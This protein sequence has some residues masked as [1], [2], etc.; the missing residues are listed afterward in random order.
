MPDYWVDSSATGGGDTGDSWVNAYLTLQQALTACSGG[1]TIW[2]ASD[3][4]EALIAILVWPSMTN[5]PKVISTSSSTDVYTK[6]PAT[7]IIAGTY[8]FKDNDKSAIYIGCYLKD[9]GDMVLTQGVLIIK[10]GILNVGDDIDFDISGSGLHLIDTEVIFTNGTSSMCLLDKGH[11]SF[12]WHG[13]TLTKAGTTTWD[14]EFIDN[15]GS[16]NLIDFRDVDLTG[17]DNA[18]GYLVNDRLSDETTHVTKIDF[19][20]CKYNSSIAG[21]M[22]SGI[23]L[24]TEAFFDSVDTTDGYYLTEKHMYHGIVSTQTAIVREGKYDGT[25]KYAWSFAGL[26]TTLKAAIPLRRKICDIPRQD[27]SSDTD[28]TIHLT[29]DSVGSGVSGRLQDDEFWIELDYSDQTDEALGIVENSLPADINS[30]SDLGDSTSA[31]W[32]GNGGYE[33][34]EVTINIGS[35]ESADGVVSI[36]ACLATEGADEVFVCPKPEIA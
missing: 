23:G 14:T 24:Y 20:R 26:A 6:A 35:A 27:L 13:G 36:Y 31:G 4:Y 2:M 8:K 22:A 1:E 30:P 19:S 12:V 21:F 18:S 15:A 10:D 11:H 34:Q 32:T 5:P 33:E 16:G 3:H 17:Y 25:N 7:Q 29:H 9:A 28:I